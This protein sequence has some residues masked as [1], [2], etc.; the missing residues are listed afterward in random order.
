M[1]FIANHIIDLYYRSTSGKLSEEEQV[2][3]SGW[4]NKYPSYATH[5][6]QLFDNEE[7]NQELSKRSPASLAALDNQLYSAIQ[8]AIHTEQKIIP[9]VHLVHLLKTAW[10]RYA[11]AIILIIGLGSAIYFQSAQKEKAVI[12]ETKPASIKK[13]IAPGF[14]R[15]VLTLS[16]GEKVELNNNTIETISDGNLSIKNNSGQLTYSPIPSVGG[17]DP[18]AGSN[19]EDIMRRGRGGSGYNTMSTPR[20]GQYQ[21]TLSDGTKVYLNAASSITYPTVFNNKTREVSIT[22]EAYF[23]IKTIKEKPFTIH[24]EKELITVLGTSFNINSYKDEP[25]SKTSLIE[26]SIKIKP[27]FTKAL[28]DEVI[29]KPGQAYQEGKIIETNIEKDIAWKNGYFNFDGA[30]LPTVMRQLSRW[31]DLE[32]KYEKQIPKVEFVGEMTRNITLQSVLKI[33]EGAG[34]KFKVENRTLTVLH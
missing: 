30:D 12:T 13:D 16:N 5:L 7:F 28:T 19:K 18:S 32:I 34:V 8:S 10:F 23:E 20:G 1:A 24:T 6:K 17:V 22:G 29:I 15:A 4:L 25:L 21:L 9:A 11:A 14:N 31:Y 27:A 26:G 33:L 2:E 3:L